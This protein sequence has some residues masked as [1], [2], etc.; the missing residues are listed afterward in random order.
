MPDVKEQVNRVGRAL[1]ENDL[2]FDYVEEYENPMIAIGF[3]GGDFS[4]THVMIHLVFDLDG[5]S[6]QIITSP[7]ASVPAEKTA[8]VLLAL[9][10]CNSRFRWV[11]FHLDEDNDVLAKS[12][13]IFDEQ[14]CADA[15]IEVVMRT[16]SI[17]D[18][19]YADIMKAVWS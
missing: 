17:I 14:N 4:Y 18:D 8:G 12:D 3:G 11:K 1:T 15:C 13:V 6:A 5:T 10:D 7:I 2:K 19:A 16:A 9:N